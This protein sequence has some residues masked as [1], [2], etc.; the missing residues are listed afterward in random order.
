MEIG[1]WN[2]TGATRIVRIEGGAQ[3]RE[4]IIECE[5]PYHFHYMPTEFQSGVQEGMVDPA[6]AHFTLSPMAPARG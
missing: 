2:H 5:R 1:P 4:T 6:V 3:F